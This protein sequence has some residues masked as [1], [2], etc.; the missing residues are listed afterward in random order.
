MKKRCIFLFL[1][2]FL[3]I[4]LGACGK[5]REDSTWNVE[6][7][8]NKEGIISIEELELG[9]LYA[10]G[11]EVSTYK[12]RYQ[13]DDCEVVSYISVPKSCLKEKEAYPCIIYNRGGNQDMELMNQNILLIWQSLLIKLF[14]QLSIGVLMEALEKKNLEGMTFMM[15]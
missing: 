12:I 1:V 3:L 13:S 8:E 9:Q 2:C 7:Y 6:Q 15:Y 14:L 4:C 11:V 10:Q 5:K